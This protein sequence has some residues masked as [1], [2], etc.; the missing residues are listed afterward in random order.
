MKRLKKTVRD[1]AIHVISRKILDLNP[2]PLERFLYR[3]SDDVVTDAIV[4]I[5]QGS[6]W[7]TVGAA[8]VQLAY[9]YIFTGVLR[10]T[11]DR[12]IVVRHN[13]QKI[14][15]FVQ[16]IENRI[17]VMRWTDQRAAGIR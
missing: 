17:K 2:Y 1:S 14:R 11:T 4:S 13:E 6:K 16:A 12:G 10:K 9:D 7:D 15:M 5:F 3:L 8:N